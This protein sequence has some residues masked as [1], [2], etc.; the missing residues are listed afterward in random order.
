MENLQEE[1]ILK[2]L[3]VNL[4]PQVHK[5]LFKNWFARFLRVS[6]GD[7]WVFGLRRSRDPCDGVE[8]GRARF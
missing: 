1:K 4:P 2:I 7:L 8:R 3:I 6:E 5:G